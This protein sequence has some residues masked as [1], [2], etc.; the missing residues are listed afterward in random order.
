MMLYRLK[1]L[2]LLAFIA[3]FAASK[4]KSRPGQV[5]VITK[6][7]PGQNETELKLNVG[8]RFDFQIGDIF[9]ENHDG[10]INVKDTTIVQKYL[11]KIFD[12]TDEQKSLADFNGELTVSVSDVTAI[13]KW[14]AGI[15]R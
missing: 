4:W 6:E 12:L 15:K 8:E 2:D 11:V 7:K 5:C 10:K 14:I 1:R 9:G 13:Q 3:I